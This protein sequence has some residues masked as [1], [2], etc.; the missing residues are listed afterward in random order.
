MKHTT[1]WG[2]MGTSSILRYSDADATYE[3]Y[4]PWKNGKSKMSLKRSVDVVPY[5]ELAS[6]TTYVQPQTV[7][8]SGLG[9]AAG[10]GILFGP[11]GAVVGA[12][13]GRAEFATVTQITIAL[14]TRSGDDYIIPILYS[15][16]KGQKSSSSAVQGATDKLQEVV[17]KVE[18]TGAVFDPSLSASI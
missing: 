14:R 4:S 12:V 5:S 17:A 8:R 15:P 2:G 9:R 18:S 7:S 1:L 3:I 16:G 6:Y 11:V 10:L 13:T